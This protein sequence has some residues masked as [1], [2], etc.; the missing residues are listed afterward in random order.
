[1][2]ASTVANDRARFS[3]TV[4][5]AAPALQCV[6]TPRTGFPFHPSGDTPSGHPNHATLAT[7]GD[8]GNRQPAAQAPA[9]REQPPTWS[10][11]THL[12]R[13]VVFGVVDGSTRRRAVPALRQ[14]FA[15]T[16][17]PSRAASACRLSSSGPQASRGGHC[18]PAP[19][20][21]DQSR[22][23]PPRLRAVLWRGRRAVPALQVFYTL[24]GAAAGCPACEIPRTGLATPAIQV[25]CTR[26]SASSATRSARQPAAM[27]P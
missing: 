20:L 26:P 11:G 16:G 15:S 24:G 10:S 8:L 19:A 3:L 6:A 12:R 5:G 23:S 2:L 4:A 13:L 7:D 27:R 18:P 17:A 21:Y 9:T 14:R 1:M 22:A 25:C